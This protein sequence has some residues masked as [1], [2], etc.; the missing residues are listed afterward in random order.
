MLATAASAAV[1]TLVEAYHMSS[2]DKD[3]HHGMQA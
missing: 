2:G 1:S 3:N